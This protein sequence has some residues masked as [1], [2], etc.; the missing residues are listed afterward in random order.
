MPTKNRHALLRESLA[1]LAG[2]DYPAIEA[3]VVN[4]GGGGVGDITDEFRSHLDIV[5]VELEQSHGPAHARNIAID[6]SSG[7]YLAFLDDDD[8]LLP[9]HVTRAMR[10]LL[11][12]EAQFCYSATMLYDQRVT[13]ADIEKRSPVMIYD[14]ANA[15]E[16]LPMTNPF[17]IDGVVCESFRDS[18]LRFDTSLPMGEDWDMWLRLTQG[19]NYRT[20]LQN[21]ATAAYIR[22]SNEE[23][24]MNSLLID[25]SSFQ[26]MYE[27]FLRI[28]ERWPSGESS[29]SR[30]LRYFMEFS[31]L[32][33][34]KRIATG[35]AI[36]AASFVQIMRAFSEH[37]SGA[38]DER[39]LR[40]RIFQAMGET[41]P[42]Y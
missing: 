13:V 27:N 14:F 8:L 16:I 41:P 10:K 35:R 29:K 24:V 11:S 22:P 17:P 40:A 42:N 30:R 33:G 20:T 19:E 21:V 9:E 15:Y 2:Q 12:S 4:D 23:S 32:I 26:G 7:K 1:S 34:L 3:V 37:I 31:Y 25:M 36:P 5:L 38:S 39:A 6:R 18:G 28:C